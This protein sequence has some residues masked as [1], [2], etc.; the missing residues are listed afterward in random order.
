MTPAQAQPSK[1]PAMYLAQGRTGASWPTKS[2][3]G[4]TVN[5]DKLLQAERRKAR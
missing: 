1:H 2:L 4:Q 5:C 3:K